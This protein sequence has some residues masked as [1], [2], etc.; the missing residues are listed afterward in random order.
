MKATT[1]CYRTTPTAAMELES[2]MQPAW[3][4]LQTKVLSAVARMQSLHSKHPIKQWIAKAKKAAALNKKIA[5]LSNLENILTQFPALAQ[6]VVEVTPWK[7]PDPWPPSQ[8]TST[9]STPNTKPTKKA[10]QTEIKKLTQSKGKELWQAGDKSGTAAHLRRI[11]KDNLTQGW[12]LYKSMPQR[13]A[14]T[15]LT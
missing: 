1:G 10:L 3:L 14:C 7:P 2:A 13:K 6:D 15:T 9:P 4:R 11:A 12:E 8:S 5:H